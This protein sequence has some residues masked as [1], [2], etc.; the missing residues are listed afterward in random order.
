MPETTGN[1]STEH[2]Q[3]EEHGHPH[4]GH[5]NDQGVRGA[6]RY[7]RWLPQM[8]RSAINDA[9]VDWS[10]YSRVNAASTSGREWALARSALRPPARM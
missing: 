9:V 2:P 8:W 1:E 4:H 7:L 6:L 10:T 5:E 3:H